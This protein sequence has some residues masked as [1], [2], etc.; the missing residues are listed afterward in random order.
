MEAQILYSDSLIELDRESI[1]LR[2]YYFPIAGKRIKLSEVESISVE[3][4]SVWNG[5]YRLYGSGD[6]QTWF[7]PDWKRWTR[8]RRFSS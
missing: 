3:K 6:L 8:E 5:K 4:P 1:L 7:P 2:G